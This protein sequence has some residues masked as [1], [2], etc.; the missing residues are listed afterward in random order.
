MSKKLRK[1]IGL[2]SYFPTNRIT[3]DLLIK[4]QKTHLHKL[5]LLKH[6]TIVCASNVGYNKDEKSSE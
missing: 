3:F 2:N 6:L 1:N 4:N 5:F